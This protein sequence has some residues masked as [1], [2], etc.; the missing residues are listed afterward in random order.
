MINKNLRFLIYSHFYY[1]NIGG[2]ERHT[3]NLAKL[4]INKGYTVTIITQIGNPGIEIKHKI[5]IVRK[6]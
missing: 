4:L 3:D 1:P 2:V 6:P 5:T